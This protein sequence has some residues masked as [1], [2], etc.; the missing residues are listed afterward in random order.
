[1][2][3]RLFCMASVNSLRPIARGML[4][5][6]VGSSL[7]SVGTLE[8]GFRPEGFAKVCR[9]GV[10]DGR[11]IATAHLPDFRSRCPLRAYPSLVLNENEY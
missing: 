9:T 5:G 2:A 10:S 1:M 7:N 8:G 4:V 6:D 3:P 11:R